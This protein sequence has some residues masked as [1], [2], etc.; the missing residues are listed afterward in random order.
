MFSEGR[1]CNYIPHPA[2]LRFCSLLLV[3]RRERLGIS[4]VR[5]FPLS[6][7][8]LILNRLPVE[9]DGVFAI[10]D[11]FFG[12]FIDVDRGLEALDHAQTCQIKCGDAV[13][14]SSFD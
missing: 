9:R 8:V 4:Y 2:E 11:D 13:F 6:C 1:K 12:I 3:T 7:Y 14:A 10:W 5:I